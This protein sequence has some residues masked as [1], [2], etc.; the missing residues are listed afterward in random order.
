MDSVV[1][2]PEC[3]GFDEIWVLVDRLSKMRHFI[4][5]YPTIDVVGLGK[6]FLREV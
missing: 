3:K 6:V 2:L 5:C 4:P 1:G